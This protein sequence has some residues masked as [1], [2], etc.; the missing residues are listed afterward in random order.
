MRVTNVRRGRIFRIAL[1]SLILIPLIYIIATWSDSD[2]EG[3]KYSKSKAKAARRTGSEV[4]VLIEGK[5]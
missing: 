3:D 5:I 1:F 2:N 4:P